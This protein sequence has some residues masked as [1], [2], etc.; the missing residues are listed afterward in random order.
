MPITSKPWYRILYIQVLISVVLGICVGILFPDTGK[1]L[2]PLA[3]AFIKMVKMI[4]APIIFCTV[5]HGIASMGDMKKLGRVGFKTLLYFEVVS[6]LALII[7]LV[8]VNILKPGVGFNIDPATLDSSL[9]SGYVEKAKSHSMLDFFLNIIPTTI[10]S[11]FTNGDLL[12]VLFIS[13]MMAFTISFMG[14]KKP[15]I[16][17]VLETAS[18]LFFGVMGIVVKFAPLGAFGAMGF[19]VGSYGLGALGKLLELMIGFYLTSALFIFIVL[20]S[21]SWWAG[22]SIFRY[23]SFIKEE[24]LLV[25]GTSSSETA[26]PGM[27]EKSIKL[28][29]SPSTVGLV[30]PSGYSFNLDGTNIYLCMAAIFLAQA[31]NTPLDLGQQIILLLVAMISSKGSSGVTG[32]GFITLAATLATVPSI[33]IESLSL[34]IGI[35]RFMSECRAIT[36]LIGNGVATVVI[37]RWE[38]ELTKEQL[39]ECLQK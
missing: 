14:E 37:S 22:F 24:L 3:D 32:A 39:N 34:L 20:G 5:V 21:I 15:I 36:N 38:G 23:L 31:T 18:K 6:T 35:D 7:G 17:N 26:L 12:Q 4:I 29:C 10:F 28:G 8:V 16:L 33:P 13:I 25:L 11:P 27:M 19:T 1:M 30:I 9:T 2:K